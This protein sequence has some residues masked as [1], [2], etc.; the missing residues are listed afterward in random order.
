[1]NTLQSLRLRA[2]A[3]RSSVHNEQCLSAV[4]LAGMVAKKT[5]ELIEVIN[6]L[7]TYIENFALAMNYNEETE[8]LEIK[9]GQV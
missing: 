6:E 9:G 1:M 8:S 3:L 4:E 2:M 5:N 7:S